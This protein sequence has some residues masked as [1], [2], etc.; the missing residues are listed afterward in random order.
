MSLNRFVCRRRRSGFTLVELLVVIGIIALLIGMLMPALARARAASQ[1]VVCAASLRQIGQGL[2]SYVSA[3]RGHG[4]WNYFGWSVEPGQMTS[5]L[6]VSWDDLLD[7]HLGRV[8]TEPERQAAY[9]PR[10]NKLYHCP[11][12]TI[13]R[14]VMP[15]DSQADAAVTGLHTRSY[16]MNCSFK[17]NDQLPENFT[18]IGSGLGVGGTFA[19]AAGYLNTQF[20][21]IN[22]RVDRVRRP[23]DVIAIAEVPWKFNVLG[24]HNTVATSPYTQALQAVFVLN[25]PGDKPIRT[26]HGTT[27]NYLFLDGSVRPM[28]GEE[29]VRPSTA[30]TWRDRVYLPNY[31]WTTDPND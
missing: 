10:P 14:Q 2:Q 1:K 8:L 21:K 3:H 20:S 17:N 7:S 23:S 27:W 26:T 16:A 18:G 5:Y 6:W 24:G 25:N 4:P 19:N 31:L 9:A 12:D 28:T 29:T 13:E 15:T 30:A 22:I 11:A